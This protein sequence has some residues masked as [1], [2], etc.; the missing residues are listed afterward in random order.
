MPVS[1]TSKNVKFYYYQLLLKIITG[2][3][4]G[5]QS[6]DS[7]A[8]VEAVIRPPLKLSCSQ[9]ASRIKTSLNFSNLK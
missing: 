8:E 3:K 9:V 7:N 2:T 1:T 5:A 6:D 4:N